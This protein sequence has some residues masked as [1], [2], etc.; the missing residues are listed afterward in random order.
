MADELN[1][2]GSLSQ[3]VDNLENPNNPTSQELNLAKDQV[4]YKNSL[5]L[6]SDQFGIDNVPG[7]T[8]SIDWSIIQEDIDASLL[9]YGESNPYTDMID[10]VSSDLEPFAMEGG[11][12]FGDRPE[13]ASPN[14]NPYDELTGDFDLTTPE[15][16]KKALQGVGDYVNK[17]TPLDIN[18][19]VYREPVHYGIKSSNLDR[20][21][22]HNHYDELGFHPFQDTESYYNRNSTGWDDWQR[23]RKQFNRMFTPAL[24]SPYRSYKDV[25][26]GK[27]SETDYEGG[28]VMRE[29]MRIGGSTRGGSTQFW[30]DLALNSSYSLGI[31]TNI[32]L[33]EM[34]LA[35]AI[36]GTGGY[37]TV[38]AP[39]VMANHARKLKNLGKFGQAMKSAGKYMGDAW[40][41]TTGPA[42][43]F[44]SNMNNMS[45]VR[46]LAAL[47][48]GTARGLGRGFT[49][50]MGLAGPE[51]LYAMRHMATTRGTAK[52]MTN[53]SKVKFTAAS[54]Y[55]D[56]RALNL[57]L[58]ESK[59]EGALVENQVYNDNYTAARQKN[60]GQAPTPEQLDDI[61]SHA[62]SSGAEATWINFPL[63]LASN[64][65]LIGGALQ[66]FKPLG[67][68]LG[69]SFDSYANKI[70]R[71]KKNIRRIFDG[72]EDSLLKR[73]HKM[74]F[75]GGSRVLAGTS[76]RFLAGN[77]AEGFQELGQEATSHYLTKY[78]TD[79]YKHELYGQQLIDRGLSKSAFE[80]GKKKLRGDAL[81]AGINAMNSKEGFHIF[82][83]GFM[84]GGIVR[85]Y[86]W[87]TMELVPRLYRQYA[88][89][90][91]WKEYVK[92]KNRIK[93]E[94]E[95]SLKDLTDNP[96]VT[97]D[98]SHI[99]ATALKMYDQNQYRAQ[100]AGDKMVYQ[101]NKHAKIFEGFSNAIQLNKTGDIKAWLK[102]LQ[103]MDDT[104]LR[105]AFPE[106]DET[107][108]KM[109]ERLGKSMEYIDQLEKDINSEKDKNPNIWNPNKYERGTPEYN[110]EAIRH[111]VHEHVVLMKI[112]TKDL[113][114]D[115]IK[116]R[117]SVIEEITNTQKPVSKATKND[118]SILL[119]R[120]D[121][122]QEISLLGNELSTEAEADTPALRAIKA[123][124]LQRLK[125]LNEI[126]EVL[127]GDANQLKEEN[128]EYAGVF[129][130]AKVKLL[131]KPMMNYLNYLAKV[132][133]DYV[134]I[135]NVD[136]FIMK[137]IDNNW[138]KVRAEEYNK[139][140]MYLE[141]PAYIEQYQERMRGV[142]KDI[143]KNAKK[144]NKEII[145][146]T[147]EQNEKITFIKL[148]AEHDIYADP[149]EVI[150]FLKGGELP[151]RWYDDKGQVN[152]ISHAEK[153]EILANLVEAYN[154][155]VQAEKDVNQ[156][157]EV[158][159]EKEV[160]RDKPF[161]E[162]REELDA[163]L[164]G[165]PNTRE[166]LEAKW[167]IY[168]SK[169]GS[170]PIGEWIAENKGGAILRSRYRLKLIYD[171]LVEAGTIEQVK[172]V[173][174]D[175]SLQMAIPFENWIV[176]KIKEKDL[177]VKKVTEKVIVAGKSFVVQYNE[178][179]NIK[180]GDT[181]RFKNSKKFKSYNTED[182]NIT[183]DIYELKVRDT[184]G[185]QYI[186]YQVMQTIQGQDPTNVFDDYKGILKNNF[187][188]DLQL[189]KEYDSSA[190]AEEVAKALV[191]YIK[192]DKLMKTPMT[193]GGLKL[194]KGD[195]VYKDNK[196]WE[197]ISSP[198]TISNYKYF[199][200][201]PVDDIQNKDKWNKGKVNS[202]Q[203]FKD[204]GFSLFQWDDVKTVVERPSNESKLRI[205]EPVQLYPF[206]EGHASIRDTD[207]FY[208]KKQQWLKKRGKKK[209]ALDARKEFDGFV[210]KATPSNLNNLKLN[211][212]KVR[213][214]D[215]ITGDVFKYASEEA[216][217]NPYIRRGAVKY[218]VTL[219][220]GTTPIARLQGL[221][222][223]VLLSDP[224]NVNS[225]V[226]G[227]NISKALA[228]KIFIIPEG[229][230]VEDIKE[231]YKIAEG[232]QKIF[233]DLNLDLNEHVTLNLDDKRL[234]GFNIQITPGELTYRLQDVQNDRYKWQ[235]LRLKTVE[236]ID[237]KDKI[238]IINKEIRYESGEPVYQIEDI[239]NY[240]VDEI[241][242]ELSTRSKI[243]A[244][245]RKNQQKGLDIKD[246]EGRLVPANLGRYTLVV[247]T[248]MDQ[249]VFIQLK[250][251][252]LDKNTIDDIFTRMQQRSD[253][254]VG[255]PADKGNIKADGEMNSVEFNDA[256]NND[257]NQEFFIASDPGSSI[258]VQVTNNGQ[259]RFTYLDKTSTI[260]R[261]KGDEVQLF[262]TRMEINSLKTKENFGEAILNLFNERLDAWNRAQKSDAIINNKA[263]EDFGTHIKYE[264]FRENIP[265]QIDLD[266]D[267]NLFAVGA[268]PEVIT[269]QKLITT[270]EAKTV[271]QAKEDDTDSIVQNVL[272][273][274]E[275]MEEAL[276]SIDA[277][278]MDNAPE[279]ISADETAEAYVEDTDFS[280]VSDK[281]LQSI[282]LKSINKIPLEAHEKTI[283]Q[284]RKDDVKG[285]M[286]DIERERSK[287][288]TDPEP[289]ARYKN[290]KAQKKEYENVE[291]T[292][293]QDKWEKKF[294]KPKRDFTEEEMSQ[295][296][297]DWFKITKKGEVFKKLK[298]FD[299]KMAQAKFDSK[300]KGPDSTT[301]PKIVS[302]KYTQDDVERT[303]SFIR[304]MK[305]TLPQDFILLEFETLDDLQ[306]RMDTAGIT[307]GLLVMSLRSVSEGITGTIY[308]SPESPFKYHEAFHTVFRLL[309]NKEQQ[310][311]Y[312]SLAKKEVIA[313]I[314]SRKGY[315]M[316][317]DKDTEVYVKSLKEAQD[318]LRN[319]ANKYSR[320][321]SEELNAEL[322]E[323]HLADRFQIFKK[324]RE[325]K[326]TGSVIKSFFDWLADIIKNIL[327]HLR[328]RQIDTLFRKIDMG[329][330]STSRVANNKHTAQLLDKGVGSTIVA[331][332]TI[333][334]GS[335]L[336]KVQTIRNGETMEEEV[337]QDK[338]LN[339]SDT[340]LLIGSIVHM[341]YEAKENA[342]VPF[343]Q[344]SILTEIV[345]KNIE[346][347]NPTLKRYTK[348]NDYLS[349]EPELT[350]IYEGL[351]SSI[352]LP[353]LMKAVLDTIE[354]R[355]EQIARTE[356]ELLDPIYTEGT[357]DQKESRRTD[358][359]YNKGLNEYGG[360]QHQRQE[361][362]DYI[363]ST[364]IPAI[365]RF[366]ES[367]LPSGE[368][369]RIPVDHIA[370]YHHLLNSMEGIQ[371][372]VTILRNLYIQSRSNIHAKA[373]IDRFFADIGLGENVVSRL[374]NPNFEIQSIGNPS[375]FYM[376]TKPLQTY[377]KGVKNIIRSPKTGHVE[378]Y[379]PTEGDVKT[380]Q[381]NQWGEAYRQKT[382]NNNRLL[383][384]NEAN[385]VL[386][387]LIKLYDS[388]QITNI[389]LEELSIEI[390]AG[391]QDTIG[392][393]ISPLTIQY[394]ISS[395]LPKRTEMQKLLYLSQEAKDNEPVGKETWVELSKALQRKLPNGKYENIFN[396]YIELDN[397]SNIIDQ[398]LDGLQGRIIKIAT[399]N[400]A[401]DISV[402]ISS[403][404]N[405]DG[406][407]VWSQSLP[408]YNLIQVSSQNNPEYIKQLKRKLI[409][410]Y[411]PLFDMP[412]YK[413]M[414]KKK[415]HR[416]VESGGLKIADVFLNAEN[417][418]AEG[419]SV[420]EYKFGS[421][422]KAEYAAFLFSKYL[423]NFNS[424]S[425]NLKLVPYDVM[426]DDGTL[427]QSS[428]AE[429]PYTIR[430]PESASTVDFQM[431]PV[432]KAIEINNEGDMNVADEA[433]D[434]AD[435]LI[436]GT[437]ESLREAFK[438][439][440]VGGT[441]IPGNRQ[442]VD[443]T[444]N[445]NIFKIFD[446]KELLRRSVVA[447]EDIAVSR[448]PILGLQ[449]KLRIIDG[450]QK[451]MLRGSDAF[452][453]IKIPVGNKRIITLTYEDKNKKK[454]SK[455]FII[456]N[457]GKKNIEQYGE[458]KFIEDL[459]GGVVSSER[460]DKKYTAWLKRKG[461]TTDKIWGYVPWNLK[462]N[463]GDFFFN[464]ELKKYIYKFEPYEQSILE[465]TPVTETVLAPLGDIKISSRPV[466]LKLEDAFPNQQTNRVY[467]V[468][469][470]GHPQADL[471]TF[472]SDVG[473]VLADNKTKKVFSVRDAKNT[474]KALV[475]SLPKYFESLNVG[476]YKILKDIGFEI[477][478]ET[479]V[480]TPSIEEA[481][482]LVAQIEKEE[483]DRAAAD[484]TIVDTTA[485]EILIKAAKNGDSYNKAKKEIEK[486]LGKSLNEV[487]SEALESSYTDMYEHIV[488]INVLPKI[489]ER[490]RAK[491]SNHGTEQN[492]KGISVANEK[493]NLEPENEEYNL[494]QIFWSNKLM[495]IALNRAIEE[496]RMEELYKD[497]VVDPIKRGKALS[498]GRETA[499]ANFTDT[500]SDINHSVKRVHM[501]AWKDE[502]VG[503]QFRVDRVGKDTFDRG[504]AGM[505]FTPKG[506]QYTF[507]GMGNQTNAQKAMMKKIRAGED[508]SLEEFLG[509]VTNPIGFKHLKA[510]IN[511]KKYM[512]RGSDG[513]MIK[514]AVFILSRQLTSIWN[515]KTKE[516]DPTPQFPHLHNLLNKLEKF[517][518]SWD[519]K[520]GT[521]AVAVPES[522]LKT[523]RPNLQAHNDLF[524]AGELLEEDMTELDAN[525][526]GLQVRNPGGK[527]EIVDPRQIK[528]IIDSEQDDSVIINIDDMEISIGEL[529]KMY[530]Q[531][532]ADRLTN[533]LLARKNLTFEQV[534]EEIEKSKHADKLTP[535]LSAF[536]KY[537]KVSLAASQSNSHMLE[538]FES[539]EYG[540][541]KFNLNNPIS[542]KDFLKF[543][544]NFFNKG[545]VAERQPGVAA[546]LAPDM[547]KPVRVYTKDAIDADGRAIIGKARI[548]RHEEWKELYRQ[549]KAPAIESMVN[550]SLLP[551]N[552]EVVIPKGQTEVYYT[553]RLRANV[554]EYADGKATGFKYFE[555]VMAA[556]HKEAVHIK[557]GEALPSVFSKAF[558]IRIPTQDK[559]S[560]ANLKI[561]DFLPPMY[562]ST[563]MVAYELI[564]ISGSDFDIDKLYMQMADFYYDE[565]GFHRYGDAKT[566]QD[567]YY[568]YMRFMFSESKKKNSDMYFAMES[569]KAKKSATAEETKP[570]Y[571][572]SEI[573]MMW[574]VWSSTPQWSPKANKFI[575]RSRIENFDEE[576]SKAEYAHSKGFRY[577]S[578]LKEFDDYYEHVIIPNE[579]YS[580]KQILEFMEG[581]P[582][583]QGALQI[584]DRPTSKKDYFNW[585][586]KRK[587]REPYR[588]FQD[589]KLL[590]YK[591]ALWGHEGMTETQQG[592]AVPKAYEPAVNDPLQ[593][594]WERL[595]EAFPA[596]KEIV[597]EQGI[598]INDI[599]GQLLSWDANH[600]AIDS[601]G[602]IALSNISYNVMGKFGIK[603]RDAG[604]IIKLN[605]PKGITGAIF[606]NR[607]SIDPETGKPNKEGY[608]TQY[609]ISSLVSVI[610][611]N[612][613]DRLA[614]KHNLNK[615][616][617]GLV[618]TLVAMGVDLDTSLLM[619]Q[620]PFIRTAYRDGYT[621]KPFFFAPGVRKLIV[622]RIEELVESKEATDKVKMKREEAA[623]VVPVGKSLLESQ[624]KLNKINTDE[625][626][627]NEIIEEI[628]ILNEWLKADEYSEFIRNLSTM[629]SMT[630]GYGI[631][632]FELQEIEDAAE[633]LGIRMNNKEMKQSSLPFDVRRIFR[634]SKGA[635]AI[636]MYQVYWDGFNDIVNNIAPALM[637]S[638]T[639]SFQKIQKKLMEGLYI[640][641][642]NDFL[643]Q[644]T[645]DI[646]SYLT[647][648]AYQNYL[649][650]VATDGALTRA[651][652]NNGLI[653][654]EINSTIKIEDSVNN[655][656]K[657]LNEEG[658]QNV[659]MQYIYL[660][661][662]LHKSNKTGITLL[663]FN[664]FADLHDDHLK[665]M[666]ADLLKLVNDP[667]TQMDTIAIINYLIVKNGLQYKKGTFIQA[668]LPVLY[669]DIIANK[670]GVINQVHDLFKG[671]VKNNDPAWEKV[672]GKGMTKTALV[673]DLI[674]GYG[675]HINSQKLVK[676]LFTG[677]K[678]KGV[679]DSQKWV[680]FIKYK[681]F[682]V[683]KLSD[684]QIQVASD[685]PS[686]LM[687]RMNKDKRNV[688]VFE[689]VDEGVDRF[690]N[691][692]TYT[693][694]TGTVVQIPIMQDEKTFWKDSELSTNKTN[695]DNAIEE[696]I[697]HEKN[698]IFHSWAHKYRGK[699]AEVL[700]R[701][702]ETFKYIRE[703]IGKAFGYDIATGKKGVAF[704]GREDLDV[705][706]PIVYDGKDNHKS[707]EY[708]LGEIEISIETDTED[709]S[710]IRGIAKKDQFK[711]L[712]KWQSKNKKV[713]DNN[714]NHILDA[715]SKDFT[716]KI[717]RK[718][719]IIDPKDDTK[720]ITLLEAPLQFTVKIPNRLVS[721]GDWKKRYFM[722]VDFASPLDTNMDK[723]FDIES[724]STIVG[725]KFIYKEYLPAGSRSTF[726]T[727][728]VI[729]G[730]LPP[731]KDIQDVVNIV[732]G[733]ETGLTDPLSEIDSV[734]VE[735]APG[736]ETST[737]GTLTEGVVEETV[738]T[739]VDELD[740]VPEE[741][742]FDP[743]T[744][745]TIQEDDISY[746]ELDEFFKNEIENLSSDEIENIKQNL[747]KKVVTL[748]D[749][750][751][752]YENQIATLPAY[753]EKQFI[754]QIKK[755]CK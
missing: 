316:V 738:E 753:T 534:V 444:E 689:G 370:V 592:R 496:H 629:L 644:N 42:R 690:E 204:Q 175:T 73:M 453:K 228:E 581:S 78:Y 219:L 722:L 570:V 46:G 732:H 665:D 394:W 503:K 406:N 312:L 404:V 446:V 54:L 168:R 441:F 536:I 211:I 598:D 291:Y 538:M 525:W 264:N 688:H 500:K 194:T 99:T 481:I 331:P 398:N 186:G 235:D 469:F 627:E 82:M 746:S 359:D 421:L 593:L 335:D 353:D 197:V 608:R 176:K 671:D 179:T 272:N 458:E 356:E 41:Y 475:A 743:S 242:N 431:L 224:D 265:Q 403:Y 537:A 715:Q 134:D 112:F 196:A 232:V 174:D 705:T 163:F 355:D 149:E 37:A 314:N 15:G 419:N 130:K 346:R 30:N 426:Q 332:A 697:E 258:E 180:L 701:S 555:S 491:L 278:D 502:Q 510:M 295:F 244:A 202:L 558:A 539:D 247:K 546:A 727:S 236:T 516:W 642:S 480:E 649:D 24:T 664:S 517:E 360:F 527:I 409:N 214:E 268:S 680:S 662:R 492:Q 563:I 573:E 402:A 262:I 141:D 55:R 677:R 199:A 714:I 646:L 63:I 626:T 609:L 119:T 741:L 14:Y 650:S 678:E 574:F 422:P 374:V 71:N 263:W 328:G 587:G 713:I 148:V 515:E 393:K 296:N 684:N 3:D 591:Y 213:E 215:Q 47:G 565:T 673:K 676:T 489:N 125:L 49:G 96:F 23:A 415:R 33:E 221:D 405:A 494:K 342:A 51:T 4:D 487:V 152:P 418:L 75:K 484:K 193:L 76:L 83:S 691:M 128:G 284:A 519:A 554:D 729:D 504:D 434:F 583:I 498:G 298:E 255:L 260:Y 425:G 483:M 631:T 435:K 243:N 156:E 395:V 239:T 371:D 674:M 654:P 589:N 571:T 93:S 177:D 253:L 385:K 70:F 350:E 20:Y 368:R 60:K 482:E 660:K 245:L 380:D 613:K 524:E 595:S 488:N 188:V 659:F 157:E 526:L 470:S 229:K 606:N 670:V 294:G 275:E 634:T 32:V 282:A 464:E 619:V 48:R 195:H 666:Q 529:R 703:E 324:K 365:D 89:P 518:N 251:R 681:G 200:F 447:K 135:E 326:Y 605:N 730:Q 617:L 381:I 399:S 116:R 231:N 126:K 344:D 586:N 755:K 222:S 273:R 545:V 167:K 330:F 28:Y 286:L 139:A 366:N 439:H 206:F 287:K 209:S 566:D 36:Y 113:F 607:Y 417:E 94:L 305:R 433:L 391:L 234:Q 508:I 147:I 533:A 292:K 323:E 575:K 532:S 121:L 530:Q 143:W 145:A 407:R 58:A 352:G 377:R 745:F 562:S 220:S 233:D 523:I 7:G 290:L 424:K 285:M 685:K 343:D 256:F 749:L 611:D 289:I 81:K 507:Y 599:Y 154:R 84:M 669:S 241:D 322:F 274:K 687:T 734:D 151:T 462:E 372:D 490:V 597:K 514:T 478:E 476:G 726:A 181:K 740:N 752:G 85:P 410:K 38:A 118:I 187:N 512:Y 150:A 137:L 281:Q 748:Q 212:Q 623:K 622:N 440:F 474:R 528:A 189:S 412:A 735:G 61:A 276:G 361:I 303:N 737:E 185:D 428:Y 35:L 259:F 675:K 473:W 140:S 465:E 686:K 362:R 511:S 455:K 107:A 652:L 696:I 31:I 645:Q 158:K 501:V 400:A 321:S 450:E 733:K 21:Y 44:M 192:R 718:R 700:K 751:D 40:R 159:E 267:L 693:G 155:K 280:T 615:K 29:A 339:A 561:V 459:G 270:F 580:R 497:P 373:F 542:Q 663:E 668:V 386:S 5:N 45:A 704:K 486:Q 672:F 64:R 11:F 357:K 313:Q 389:K 101:D 301:A 728:H 115:S 191:L 495:G 396:N 414:T 641:S 588:A 602:A 108:E 390:A 102:D 569:W 341:Y 132:N 707:D 635:P 640:Y 610:V 624:V 27:F 297:L 367:T 604:S 95:T 320:M 633:E 238:W 547:Y 315:K 105:K 568:D 724:D 719:T 630:S 144:R 388:T 364:T 466:Q 13:K 582:M 17:T 142:F 50:A 553:D 329:K 544:L 712:R 271:E 420:D 720:Q 1:I 304:F 205:E 625:Y 632:Q 333:T 97:L 18:K 661:D 250:G 628:A 702:P 22:L 382:D 34:L 325:G 603:T 710:T 98:K 540:Q 505:Y 311:R 173:K 172:V 438:E 656:N 198:N 454:R 552:Y 590:D 717:F 499:G 522:A 10:I 479:T 657:Y 340:R 742:D 567:Q 124:K 387:K 506:F 638:F 550:V 257:L 153:F 288:G 683:T 182:E 86:T 457:L 698:V 699:L 114:R 160:P 452:T 100:K 725:T 461:D 319:S 411:N 65:L 509:T 463:I 111:K 648:K 237:G 551:N 376:I 59:M 269:N 358:S 227:K 639:D 471:V 248:P 216:K 6:N 449:E 52:A 731:F 183:I 88:Q 600:V 348:R 596:I 230:T 616:A 383:K 170:L 667:E 427:K 354:A 513:I 445:G 164:K 72:A 423:W 336:F 178:L 456:T 493:L 739:E 349:I 594:A 338:S 556:H 26:G 299:K 460:V 682:P 249:Y 621:D 721:E 190:K 708:I 146:N 279:E 716:K 694:F 67:R 117:N 90:E 520:G 123:D 252:S 585:K 557:P 306:E 106:V 217:P 351:K 12:S 577:D 133:K 104:E 535:N 277:E 692:E 451:I 2:T 572:S 109:K 69:E 9:K 612:A 334:Y 347:F 77:I 62:V 468:T 430:I 679:G 750:I 711:A 477:T 122:D 129:D 436:Q 43:K 307:A 317:K 131:R 309:L 53:M 531:T 549:G 16:Q 74:G 165:D 127:Y 392:I 548:L 246:V 379:D 443:D 283:Y 184:G 19:E 87:A 643:D 437:Y 266:S 442:G 620:H 467:K 302:N 103:N 92:E 226:L 345:F 162:T 578:D 378:F 636:N 207:P 225:I 66:G 647:I 744:N 579:N 369:I 8:P 747:K 57:A 308:T 564:E 327:D 208:K 429:I 658:K 318:V 25:F 110:D 138:L 169:G 56:F 171:D 161:E 68:L 432:L 576:R 541:P 384:F 254:T 166:V 618:G 521:I 584:L 416:V 203:T 560:A 261:A 601:V 120:S 614:H 413:D 375:F 397:D 653:Y 695:I 363:S 637:L 408:S 91:Q 337:F 223:V 448:A 485:E 754:E 39:A 201:A 310:E 472:K 79:L 559:H 709:I 655:I 543:L 293:L 706:G 723:I 210:K 80:A 218:L 401:T 136:D 736:V 240:T 300:R 651:S